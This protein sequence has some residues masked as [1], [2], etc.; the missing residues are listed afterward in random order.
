MVDGCTRLHTPGKGG[1]ARDR[2]KEGGLR[3]KFLLLT[4]P[5]FTLFIISNVIGITSPEYP[6]CYLFVVH[7]V[8]AYL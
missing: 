5:V 7:P 2:T 6:L 1:I 4:F 3:V 8:L